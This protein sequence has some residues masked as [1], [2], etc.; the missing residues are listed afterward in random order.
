[1]AEAK[2]DKAKGNPEY[3]LYLGAAEKTK[4]LVETGTKAEMEA[5]Q[6]RYMKA[7][8]QA[9]AGLYSEIVKL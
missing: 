4:I 5:L 8:K 2:N 9:K 6:D 1:M 3:A 7:Y